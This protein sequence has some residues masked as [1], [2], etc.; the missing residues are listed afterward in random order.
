MIS[1]GLV[2]FSQELIHIPSRCR[3]TYDRRLLPGETSESVLGAIASHPGTADIVFGA[4][5][6]EGEHETYTG[7]TL[8]GT[9]FVPAWVFAEEHRFVQAALR[10]PCTS[11]LQPEI[12]AYRFCTNAA[13][14]A[15]VLGVPT[16]GFCPAAE[17][18]AHV[19]DE[20]LAL[21]ELQAALEGYR[22]IIGAVLA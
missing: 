3:A 17:G 5:I 7:G 6:A 21:A 9:K 10:G 4:A 20:R 15:G 18:D 11:G 16:V 14:S 22:G 8:R 13:S 12:G 19:V 1:H 2:R